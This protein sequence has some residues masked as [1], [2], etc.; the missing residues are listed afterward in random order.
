[1]WSSVIKSRI[2]TASLPLNLLMEIPLHQRYPT[3][4]VPP[5]DASIRARGFTSGY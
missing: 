4:F 5:P 3:K 1:L 2:V